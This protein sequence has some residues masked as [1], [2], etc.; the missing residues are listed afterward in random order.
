MQESIEIEDVVGGCLLVLFPESRAP[1]GAE[2][3]AMK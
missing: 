1:S 3:Q 2:Y